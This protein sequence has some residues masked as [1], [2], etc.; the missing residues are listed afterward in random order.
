[1]RWAVLLLLSGILTMADFSP[2][3]LARALTG[4]QPAAAQDDG[5]PPL[6]RKIYPLRRRYEKTGDEAA[7]NQAREAYERATPEELAALRAWEQSFP[8]YPVSQN[9]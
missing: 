5:R 8:P 2:Q 3:D 4:A 1:M 7:Y 9:A 6:A